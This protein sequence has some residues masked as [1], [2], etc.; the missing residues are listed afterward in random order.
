[1]N[2]RNDI[3][4]NSR[5]DSQALLIPS[6]NLNNYSLFFNLHFVKIMENSVHLQYQ[7]LY[8]NSFNRLIKAINY[9]KRLLEDHGYLQEE[10]IYKILNLLF[11]IDF[12]KEI[13]CQGT[14]I[15]F[16]GLLDIPQLGPRTANIAIAIKDQFKLMKLQNE[17]ISLEDY[18]NLL[19]Y[20]LETGLIIEKRYLSNSSSNSSSSEIDYQENFKLNPLIIKDEE[21]IDTINLKTCT[22]KEKSS[23]E[24]VLIS[25]NK[26]F[27]QK[28]NFKS[29]KKRRK[30]L[31]IIKR[32]K[33][34]VCKGK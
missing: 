9:S 1:M 5:K 6:F 32:K 24:I 26:E 4:N 10:S 23:E 18:M 19:L 15:Q 13:H 25:T 3:I 14:E 22:I 16:L 2:G 11:G 29:I 28:Q 8:S 12:I 33:K 34:K 30:N 17:K 7:L 20:R 21:G 27:K 31:K